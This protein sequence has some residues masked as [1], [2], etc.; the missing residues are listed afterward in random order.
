[1][2]NIS[3][4]L[5]FDSI[6]ISWSRSEAVEKKLR[7]LLFFSKLQFD[8]DSRFATEIR[9]VW[10]GISSGVLN[11]TPSAK[12]FGTNFPRAIFIDHSVISP[13]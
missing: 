3:F 2:E 5:K 13:N 11:R 10:N 6:Q 1:M 7:F 8:Q 4:C 9:S 12:F